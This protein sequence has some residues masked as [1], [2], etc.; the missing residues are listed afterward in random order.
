MIR[1]VLTVTLIGLAGVF[2][3]YKVLPFVLLLL[4]YWSVWRV[5]LL[6]LQGSV[7]FYALAAAPALLCLVRKPRR[8]GLAA[9]AAVLIPILAVVPPLMSQRQ[10][11]RH[12]EG[13]LAD[14]IDTGLA[15]TPKSVEIVSDNRKYL[16]RRT[17]LNDAPCEALCQRLLLSRQVDLVRVKLDNS[18]RAVHGM[19][20]VLETRPKTCPDAFEESVALLPE[21]KDAI[22]S[23]TCFVAREPGPAPMSPSVGA[24]RIEIRKASFA[25]PQ[26]LL[27]D[28]SH[29]GDLVRGLQTL[30]ISV[31]EP[32]GWSLRLK[33]TQVVFSH[34][35]MP[36][37]LAVAECS[38]P[39]TCAQRP[40]FWRD[41]HTIGTFD[42]DELVL[43][44]LGIKPLDSTKRLSAGAR[45]TAM[46]DRTGN[47]FGLEEQRLVVDW[48]NS[49]SCKSGACG[50]VAGA[51][52]AVLQ[53]LLTDSRTAY[54]LARTI[55]GKP[56]FVADNF[57]M[58]LD[59]TEAGGPKGVFSNVFGTAVAGLDIETLRARR[60]RIMPLIPDNDWRTSDSIGILSGR[61]GFDTADMISERLGRPASAEAA[62]MAACI[63]DVDIGQRLVPAL[64]TYLRARDPKKDRENHAALIV[65]RALARFGHFDDV[66][67]LVRARDP[68]LARQYEKGEDAADAVADIS[69]CYRR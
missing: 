1:R 23:G 10:S 65:I 63:A 15:D 62:A 14:D 19:D 53:R 46:L 28:W 7:L 2:V 17:L 13:L 33:K 42:S 31:A 38:G 66:K 39:D 12:V 8:W 20:Y 52:A 16:G 4:F 40:V 11:F 29:M 49:V 59:Q 56:G 34:W 35:S 21:T 48:V 54:L 60:D 64:L 51:D 9:C 25:G 55:S 32:S 45:V 58:V 57:D 22:L 37:F 41:T 30:Q 68:Y 67:E 47:Y 50:P 44:T 26:D 36:L 3:L 6:A 24:A 27:E 69:R 61:L 5:G 18:P 43:R